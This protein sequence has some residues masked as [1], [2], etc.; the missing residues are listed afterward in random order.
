[1]LR[2]GFSFSSVIAVM[3]L[4]LG[5]LSCVSQQL[6]VSV[7]GLIEKVPDLQSTD[8]EKQSKFQ[9]Q[10]ILKEGGDP[11]ILSQERD[12]TV[13]LAIEELAANSAL[14]QLNITQMRDGKKTTIASPKVRVLLG[15][16]VVTESRVNEPSEGE[17]KYYK[18][19]L[20]PTLR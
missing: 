6:S 5:L 11:V 1:M 14:L 7:D 13:S 2:K 10:I 17:L 3:I 19:A 12:T 16:K 9:S 18:F 20:R 15:E 4:A 8:A